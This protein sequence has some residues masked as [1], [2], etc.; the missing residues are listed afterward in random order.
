MRFVNRADAGRQLA[1]S[2]RSRKLVDPIVIGV[3][4]GGV[5]V[6]AELA[7][8]L[9]APLDIC[10]VRNVIA[11]REPPQ[12]IGAVAEG[13]AAFLDPA[14]IAALEIRDDEVERE[15]ALELDE[16]ERLG[17]LLRDGPRLDL[18]DRNIILVDDAL[19][20]GTTVRAAIRALRRS[21]K[22]IDLAVPVAATEVVERLTPYV[23]HLHCLVSERA[24]T[25]VGARYDSFEPVSEA[26]VA[27]AVRMRTTAP[28]Q[29]MRG[30]PGGSLASRVLHRKA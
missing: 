15:V 22:S 20:T 17:L 25:A 13:G 11:R 8:V 10:V 2:L 19:V 6:A 30:T 7:R 23:D 3:V 5:P 1:G 12:V 27:A 29:A 9:H 24:M 4:R 16:V 26:E 18:R 28:A 21:A 14:R